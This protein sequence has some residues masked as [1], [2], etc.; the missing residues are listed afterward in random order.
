[1][2]NFSDRITEYPQ[3]YTMTN[4]ADGSVTLTPKPGTVTNAGTVLNRVNMM[5]LQGF[6]ACDTVFN[7]DGSISETFQDGSVKK[8]VFNSNGSITETFRSGT[9]TMNKIT[10][11]NEDGSISEVIS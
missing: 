5:A 8:T 3:R 6:G 2:I 4:N 10:N 9:Q 11:F 7:S 1:M